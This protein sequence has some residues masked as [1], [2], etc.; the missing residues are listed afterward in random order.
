LKFSKVIAEAP[1]LLL[2]ATMPTNLVRAYLPRLEA[3]KRV[4]VKAP[5]TA[6]SQVR[7]GWGKTTLLPGG[8]K[9]TIG[10]DGLPAEKLP[11]ILAELRDFVAGQTR[12]ERSLVI[13]YMDAKAAFAGLPGVETAH[14]NL[15]AGRDEWKDVRHLFVIG[16]PRPRSDQ[17]R[18]LA[19]ALTGEPVEMAESH[20]ETRG[21][22]LLD[23]TIGTVEVRAYA[24][25]AAEA[26]SAAITDAE[27]VQAIGRARGINRT[28]ADPVRVWIMADVVTPLL[29][30]ELLD[31]RD[32]APSAVERMA[33]R[34]GVVLT[35]GADA[36]KAFPDLFASADAGRKAMQ[37]AGLVE[38]DF[39]DNP[40]KMILLEGCP[41]KLL[42]FTYR[43]K[44]PGQQTRHGWARP[45]TGS[46]DL[47]RRLRNWIGEL[48]FFTL[49]DP[50]T[51]PTSPEGCSPPFVKPRETPRTLPAAAGQPCQVQSPIVQRSI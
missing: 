35:S 19:A 39:W 32:L 10:A 26:V 38:Q 36:A 21:V 27:V 18:A 30:D 29:V 7:R 13:T 17:V 43:P 37:R 2:D 12:G 9:L 48:A 5:H 23:G 25:P 50:S 3:V 40:L 20:K 41:G 6:V 45:G 49:V 15:V 33:M 42:R 46:E 24:N 44:G 4:R 8:L 28:A 34:A 1:A 11:Q 14:F 47:R 16:C 51:Q 22:R 31:W